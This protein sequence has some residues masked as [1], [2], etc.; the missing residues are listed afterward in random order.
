M[1]YK[2]LINVVVVHQR[3]FSVSTSQVISDR[4]WSSL[5]RGCCRG[6]SLKANTL[7]SL[8]GQVFNTWLR[9]QQE[10]GLLSDPALLW[11]HDDLHWSKEEIPFTD[12]CQIEHWP[13]IYQSAFVS[14]NGGP[15]SNALLKTG[16][17]HIVQLF[18]CLL[19]RASRMIWSSFR[20][21]VA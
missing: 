15:S 5:Y 1:R 2:S 16:R 12:L 8:K 3:S 4:S 11:P 17:A 6:F 9:T 19:I 21:F 13:L 14:R 7:A 10:K 18:K 20:H